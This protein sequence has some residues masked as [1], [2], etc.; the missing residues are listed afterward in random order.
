MI[1]ETEDGVFFG[2][3]PVEMLLH[4][5]RRARAEDLAVGAETIDVDADSEELARMFE[6]Y[7]PEIVVVLDDG[8]V[9]GIVTPEDAIPLIRKEHEEDLA[10]IFSMRGVEH[11]WTSVRRAIRNRTPW[12]VINLF[13]AFIAASVVNIFESTIQNLALLAVF[14]PIVPGEA[15]NATTQTMAIVVR[16]LA[17]GELDKTS[18]RRVFWK[19]FVLGLVNGLIIGLIALAFAI[20]W[21]GNVLAAIALAIAMPIALIVAGL[22]GVAIPIILKSWGRTRRRRPQSYSQPSRTWW[23]SPRSWESQRC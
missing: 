11:V 10:K 14:M 1:V 7:A 20:I 9:M 3:I 12:L 8:K 13:T 2:V 6:T 22:I 19:E 15:G 23:A 5:P 21:K 18:L 16:G 17:T 4:V